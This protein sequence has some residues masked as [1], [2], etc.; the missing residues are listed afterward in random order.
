M[1]MHYYYI[2]LF[3]IS[4]M[5]VFNIFIGIKAN[6]NFERTQHYTKQINSLTDENEKL[7]TLWKELEGTHMKNIYRTAYT[8]LQLSYLESQL[9]SRVNFEF[10]LSEIQNMT[11]TSIQVNQITFKDNSIHIEATTGNYSDI[12]YYVKELD[13]AGLFK[14]VDYDFE[15]ND[16]TVGDYIVRTLNCQIHLTL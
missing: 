13:N 3:L 9:N 6:H 10:Y 16:K 2:I 1:K 14:S 8:K 4:G 5:L 11:P 12:G 15:S 7:T